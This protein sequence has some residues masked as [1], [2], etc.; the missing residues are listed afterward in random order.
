M[1]DDKP[2]FY[3]S[4]DEEG[5]FIVIDAASAEDAA[6][7]FAWT[8][9]IEHD[10]SGEDGGDLVYVL[11]ATEADSCDDGRDPEEDGWPLDVEQSW[12]FRVVGERKNGPILEDVS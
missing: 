5:Y 6:S 7:E 3:V 8:H 9:S 10:P 4:S 1:S 12:T 11:L 2:S